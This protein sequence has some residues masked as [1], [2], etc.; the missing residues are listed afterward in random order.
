MHGW[1][2]VSLHIC[3]QEL[4]ALRETHG[5]EPFA[6]FWDRGKLLSDSDK[7]FVDIPRLEDPFVN[8][9]VP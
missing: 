7:L 8:R 9:V 5:I 1:G 6:K 3:A 4:A 2:I